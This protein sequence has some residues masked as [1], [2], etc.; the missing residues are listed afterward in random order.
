MSLRRFTV[1]QKVL[2]ESSLYSSNTPQ[3]ASHITALLPDTT[4]YRVRSDGERHDRIV[5]EDSLEEAGTRPLLSG[6]SSAEPARFP[7]RDRAAASRPQSHERL[8]Y[9]RRRESDCDGA[10]RRIRQ[11]VEDNRLL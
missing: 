9:A 3:A 11:L 7:S 10:L 6:A 8:E 5:D 4:Q 1:G 2:V